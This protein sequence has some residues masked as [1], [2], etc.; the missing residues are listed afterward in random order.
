[1]AAILSPTNLFVPEVIPEVEYARKIAMS[2]SDIFELLIVAV[3][4]IL[5]E[6][7]QFQNLTYFVTWWRHEWRHEYV[8]I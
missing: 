6:I 2:I 5:T 1:M 3:T 4:Q 8:F 7:Y